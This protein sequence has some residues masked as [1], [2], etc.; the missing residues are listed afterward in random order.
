[1][2]NQSL[3]EIM[4][5]LRAICAASGIGGEALRDI[6]NEEYLAPGD[7]ISSSSAMKWLG[8]GNASGD[9]LLAVIQFNSDHKNKATKKTK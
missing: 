7:G 2:K 5:S 1:M 6:L 8:G 9:N 3:C 4:G